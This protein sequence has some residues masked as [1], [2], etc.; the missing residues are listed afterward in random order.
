MRKVLL[1]ALCML[2]LA[3]AAYGQD[4]FRTLGGTVSE[5]INQNFIAGDEFLEAATTFET[6]EFN[7]LQAVVLSLQPDANNTSGS[8]SLSLPGRHDGYDAWMQVEF[9]KA[10]GNRFIPIAQFT[11]RNA[12]GM[13]TQHHTLQIPASSFTTYDTHR[14]GTTRYRMMIKVAP[15]CEVYIKHLRLVA[16]PLGP[17]H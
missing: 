7:T 15:H 6:Q 2:M 14:K 10:Y 13:T 9:R 16:I 4:P 8:I 1:M 3:G 17:I 11:W 5:E 12:E